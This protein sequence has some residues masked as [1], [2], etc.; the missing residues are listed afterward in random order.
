MSRLG[1]SLIWL[2]GLGVV[3]WAVGLLVARIFEHGATSESDEFRVAA[4]WGRR[5]YKNHSPSFCSGVAVA[6]LGGVDLDLRRAHL[7]PGGAELA[8]RVYGGAIQVQVPST[9]RVELHKDLRGGHIELQLPSDLPEDAP[10][11]DIDALIVAGG[12]EI[13]S[14]D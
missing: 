5:S 6:A 1:R 4:F 8:L 11:L 2:C 14:G 3:F 9:W 12:L 10:V 7:H 13:R